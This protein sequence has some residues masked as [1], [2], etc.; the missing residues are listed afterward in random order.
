MIRV[1]LL[2]L[3]FNSSVFAQTSKGTKIFTADI[4]NFWVAYDSVQTTKDSSKQL[5]FIQS[6]YLDKA[7]DGLKDF[8]VLRQHAAKKHLSNILAYPKFWTSLR[9]HTLQIESHKREIEA[10]MIRFK[11]LYPAFKQPDI[12]F[13][14]GCLNSGGTASPDKILI[15]S[16]IAAADKTVDASELGSWLQKVFKD[17]QNVVN[18]VAHEV[19]HT[20]QRGGDTED[21]G[22]SNLLGYCI[23]EGV[24]DFIAELLVQKIIVTPY[25]TYGQAHEAEVWQAFQ[26]EMREKETKNWLYNG[27]EAPSGQADLGYFVGYEI[28][29]SYYTNAKNKKQALKEIIELDYEN[30]S[31]SEFLQKSKYADKRKS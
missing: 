31:I 20:Q 6:L 3:I 12:Y 8:M 23:K 11:N 15:G 13:T 26:K 24:C 21:D 1:T 4:D 28:C 16:E 19:G 18:L 17:Q 30:K 27:Q 29:K 10:L 9:P 25:K 2:L 5:H 7:T 14:I 22:T